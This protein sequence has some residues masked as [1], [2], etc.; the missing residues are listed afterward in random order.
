MI[1]RIIFVLPAFQFY[2]AMVACKNIF[3]T[4]IDTIFQLGNMS[5]DIVYN[6]DNSRAEKK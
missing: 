2:S 6:I 1:N 3:I 5:F 4:Y